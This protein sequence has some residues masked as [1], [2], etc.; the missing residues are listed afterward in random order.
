MTLPTTLI[1]IDLETSGLNPREDSVLEICTMLADFKSPL[2]EPR[3]M[4]E[5][6]FP[7]KDWSDVRPEVIE[8]HNKS[9]LVGDCLMAV[10]EGRQYTAL[11]EHDQLLHRTYARYTNTGEKLVLAGSTVHF[12]LNF[13]RVHLPLFAELLSHR[14]YDVSAIKMFCYS[15]GMPEIPK[16][17][18]PSHRAR[19][20]IMGSKTHAKLC[21]KWL[22]SRDE[23]K[24]GPHASYDT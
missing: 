9:G 17:N 6:V 24:L 12:D 5:K 22:D 21:M 3:S 20:D 23:P 13:I 4:I 14:V 16:D 7:F 1:W 15:L 8:M 19:L 2:E 18:G 10:H 11:Q